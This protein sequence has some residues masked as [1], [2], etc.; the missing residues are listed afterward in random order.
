MVKIVV[1]LTKRED[2]SSEQFRSEV[3]KHLPVLTSLPGLQRMVINYVPPTPDG[4]TP[5]YDVIVEDWFESPE[6]MQ[7][8][9]GGKEWHTVA[10]VFN[11]NVETWVVE[12]S[13]IVPG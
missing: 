6:A 13:T 5:Q 1:L 3:D 12:E 11:D 9:L 4:V 2:L 10:A 8:A 7:R